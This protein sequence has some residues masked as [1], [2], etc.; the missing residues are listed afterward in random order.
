V[1]AGNVPVLV[2]NCGGAE[3]A[4]S[5]QPHSTKCTCADGGAPRIV[6]NTGG[7]KGDIGTRTQDIGLQI[8]VMDQYPD[9]THVAGGTRPQIGVR[10]PSGQIKF[11]DLTFENEMGEPVYYQTADVNPDGT[12][13]D[14][15]IT[16]A[17]FLQQWGGGQVIMVPKL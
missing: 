1:I 14:R 9:W 10:S 15:E 2:H 16:N 11:P 3:T 6:R 12:F 5:G 8:D 4:P 13:T 17:E 7:K